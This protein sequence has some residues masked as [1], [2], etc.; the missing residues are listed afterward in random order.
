MD[1]WEV[2]FEDKPETEEANTNES[3]GHER[4]VNVGKVERIA[5][6]VG[7]SALIGYAL[8][9]RTKG[10]IALGLLGAGLLFRGASGQCEAYRAFGINTAETSD[11][12]VA[13]DVHIQK[14]ITINETPEHL[15]KFWRN[16]ENLP[17]S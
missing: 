9:S 15:Y 13:R 4:G 1:T 7:G 3:N 10:G 5:S 12:D 16:F 6:A 8:K 14:S 11:E 17:V 2:T